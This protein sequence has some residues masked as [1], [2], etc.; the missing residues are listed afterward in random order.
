MQRS[1]GQKYSVSHDAPLLAYLFEILPDRSRTAVKNLLAKGQVEVNGEVRTAFDAP[2]RS[3]DRIVILPKGISMAREERLGAREALEKTGVR[4]LFED[5]DLMVVDKPAGMPTVA[6]GKGEHERTLYAL[7]LAYVKTNA[8]AQ[9]KE[10]GVAGETPD[11]KQV[12]RVWIVHRLDKGTSGL[13][14][15]AKKERIKDILQSKWK[16]MVQERS[17]TAFLEGKV[18]PESGAIQ[19][20]L[21]ENPKSLKM[22]CS[23]TEVKDWQL[24]I[25]HYRVEDYIYR[26]GS[27]SV[28][29]TRTGFILETGRK[30]QIRAHAAW[31]GHP[32]C[33]DDKYGAVTNPIGRLALHAGTLSFRHPTTGKLLRFRSELPPEFDRFE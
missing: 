25:S 17:Y 15:F 22:H 8:R 13:L 32:I 18:E 4:I 28:L 21:Y 12:N 10:A 23:D 31:I 27:K 19:T 1:P 3:G 11:R 26:R 16:D 20:W 29:C 6:T 33:G 2:L 5:D 30:N 9:R 24:A 14:V 7:L